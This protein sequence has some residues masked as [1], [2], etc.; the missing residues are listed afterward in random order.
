[1]SEERK[2]HISHLKAMLRCCERVSSGTG[3]CG[4]DC[5]NCELQYAKGNMGEIKDTLAY[6]ISSLETDEAYQLEYEQPEFCE[7]CISREDACEVIKSAWTIDDL[8]NLT[9]AMLVDAIKDLP[10]VLPK[11]TK[12]DL[13]VDFK[14]KD[15]VSRE[16]VRRIIKSPRTQEQ[17]LN[18]LNSLVSV[19]PK[20]KT[21]TENCIVCVYDEIET[22]TGVHCKKCLDG[23]SQYRSVFDLAIKALEQEPKWIPVS[24][25][26]PDWDM[27]CLVIDKNGE[28]GVGYYR[29]DAAA[30]DSPNW[31]WLER[32]DRVDNK[33]AFTQPCGIGKVVAWL[34]LS[35]L[36]KEVEK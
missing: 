33:E 9:E 5:D 31:G 36:Y 28:Y 8:D 3:N 18:A 27:E 7:D 17:M 20:S 6:A 21:F 32:K 26:L 23:D 10:S 4:D 22:E 13:G 35:Q 1:M 12:D 14:L 34:P 16:A 15:Y 2:K 24:E 11:A 30:W 29:T 19:Y 25:R